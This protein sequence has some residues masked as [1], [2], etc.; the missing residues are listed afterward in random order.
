MI[1]LGLD[2]LDDVSVIV[3]GQ[4]LLDLGICNT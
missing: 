3:F 2:S 4:C 1:G